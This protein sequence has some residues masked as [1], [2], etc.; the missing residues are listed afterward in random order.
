MLGIAPFT[1]LTHAN[2]GAPPKKAA[3]VRHAEKQRVVLPLRDDQ[4]LIGLRYDEAREAEPPIPII[5]ARSPL[6][7]S[8][9]AAHLMH[10]AS[11]S[12]DSALSIRSRPSSCVFVPTNAGAPPPRP[13]R[14][15]EPH[16]ALRTIT[17]PGGAAYQ[18]DW[19]WDY[20]P[21]NTESVWEESDD[22]GEDPFAYD[23]TDTRSS[24]F[25]IASLRLAPRPKA[26]SLGSIEE[27]GRKSES[28]TSQISVPLSSPSLSDGNTLTPATSPATP[29]TDHFSEK[30]VRSLSFLSSKSAKP[31]TK[32][33]KK[34]P[35]RKD[36]VASARYKDTWGIAETP[37]VGAHEAPLRT[38][39]AAAPKY[40]A[41]PNFLAAPGTPEA[42]RPPKPPEIA[43]SPSTNTYQVAPYRLAPYPGK[44][45][46]PRPSVS[47]SG[48]NLD[49]LSPSRVSFSHRASLFYPR[50]KRNGV[51]MSDRD[52]GIATDSPHL[53]E[54]VKSG[55][56]SFPLVT[57]PTKNTRLDDGGDDAT[58]QS[59][60]EPA[61]NGS[62]RGPDA[63]AD[64]ATR[65]SL[66]NADEQRPPSIRVIS[67]EAE[68]E[69]QKVRSLYE[70]AEGL[71]W[72]DG[73]GCPSLDERLEPAAEED[74]PS[75]GDGNDAP[76]GPQRGPATIDRVTTASRHV[77]IA[78][79]VQR[80]SHELAGGF[81]DWEGVNGG[82]VDRFGFISPQR[83]TT[84]KSESSVHFSP[85]KKRNVLV[86]RDHPAHSLTVKSRV[87]RRGSALS[88]NSH[89]SELST[90]SHRSTRSAFRQA[91]N[92]LPHNRDRRLVDEAGNSLATQPGLTNIAEDELAEKLANEAKLK[93]VSRSEKWLRMA[94]VVRRGDEGQGMIFEFDPRHPKLV[95]RTWK[96]IPDCW[97][98]AAWYSF[99]SSSAQASNKPFATD[100]ELKADFRRLV[101]EPS[102]DDVQID[103]DVP[104]TINQHIMFRRRYRGGQRLLF[105]VLHALSLYFP[106]TGYVQGMAPLVATLLSYYE[107]ESCFVMLVRLWQYR[108]LSQMYG[109]RDS[110]LGE[111]MNIL[112]DFEK[113]WLGDRDV[114]KQLAELGIHPTAYATRWYMT[115]FNLS[116]PFV[117]Q[118]RVWDVFMLLGSAPTEPPSPALITGRISANPAPPSQGL[119][120]LHATC[121]AIIDCQRENLLDSD[122]ENAMRAL[123][124]W[125]PI[126]NIEHF[127]A[128]V[129]IEWKQHQN[130]HRRP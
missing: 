78:R 75:H 17:S 26:A 103:M 9:R 83:P 69:S 100:D 2:R 109:T 51:I 46:S 96:G 43:P 62:V 8:P 115:L 84:S 50:H 21:T 105:R 79:S 18:G 32:Q 113:Y 34:K 47:I 56:R 74:V 45:R 65:Y 124:S 120:I 130:R 99:L 88:L 54:K 16:P 72:E 92:L 41:E 6:R 35:A 70:S 23:K 107:E 94:K 76:D 86:R 22:E 81:E 39:R 129:Q 53:N 48:S 19:R 24:K 49:D 114:A 68:K 1:S 12:L 112:G 111:L 122:F 125:I 123:T 91:T 108:G 28:S 3:S 4:G 127:M 57:R 15:N 30:L 104:R 66:A 101:E 77:S 102:P 52:S 63:D 37:V 95:S 98:S 90:A 36:P 13:P 97:R 80:R 44:D 121:A 128:V 14:P 117:V 64:D 42:P 67:I 20:R 61:D 58:A 89:A 85:Q 126:K 5:P 110:E 33:L 10:R 93:E 116:I 73:G 106:E 82:D 7:P 11:N 59:E 119:E 71:N 40:G 38:D 29:T 55:G 87:G 60:P 25:R 31:S 27:G 118:L